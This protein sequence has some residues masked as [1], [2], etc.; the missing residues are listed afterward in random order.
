VT[1]STA[2][3]R[4]L[5]LA[6]AFALVAISALATAWTASALEVGDYQLEPCNP[7]QVTFR[8]Y[9]E[10]EPPAGLS[11]S[12]WKVVTRCP[13]DVE[14]QLES[15]AGLGT[16]WKGYGFP[17][18]NASGKIIK[19]AS[20]DLKGGDGSDGHL[21]Q[22]VLICNAG[23]QCSD[24]VQPLGSNDL[25]ARPYEFSGN[26]LPANPTKV[27]FLARCAAPPCS[28]ANPLR[29]QNLKIVYSD[30]V[31]PAVEFTDDPPDD[32]YL[33]LIPYVPGDPTS[34]NGVTTKLRQVHAIATDAGSGV[35]HIRFEFSHLDGAGERS[36]GGYWWNEDG[37]CGLMQQVIGYLCMP[38]RPDEFH[39]AGF[40]GGNNFGLVAGLNELSVQATDAAGN[41]SEPDTIAFRLDSTLPTMT[42][43]PESAG[44][45]PKW[46]AGTSFRVSWVNTGETVPTTTASGLKSARWTISNAY[47]GADVPAYKGEELGLRTSLDHITLPGDGLWTVYPKTVDYAN[48]VPIALHPVTVGVDSTVLEAPPVAPIAPVGGPGLKTGS[49]FSWQKPSNASSSP[50]GIC[51]YAM[52][53]DKNQSSDPGAGI[54]IGK[55][56]TTARLPDPLADGVNHLHFRAINCAG[57]LGKVSHVAFTVDASAPQIELTEPGPGGWYSDQYPLTASVVSPTEG[58]TMSLAYDEGSQNFETT[59]YINAP[60]K[61]GTHVLT[62]EAQDS[63]GNQSTLVTRVNIDGAAPVV[64]SSPGD[65]ANPT[66]IRG[67]ANDSGSGVAEAYLQYRAAGSADW[68]SF[69]ETVHPEGGTAKHLDLAGRL[70]DTALPDGAYEIQAVARDNAGHIGASPPSEVALPLRMAPQ[71]TASF[72]RAVTIEVCKKRAS[73]GKC[74]KKVK[75]RQKQT[76]EFADA[77][78]GAE[79]SMTGKLLDANGEPLTGAEISVYETSL[80]APRTFKQRVTT[81]ANGQYAYRVR[82]GTSRRITAHFEG[83]DLNAP[84]EAVGRFLVHPKIEFAVSQH[85]RGRHA[86][87]T[88]SGK[89]TATG[90]AIPATGLAFEIEYRVP[91]AKQFALSGRTDANGDFTLTRKFT[92]LK[93]PVRFTVRA[94]VPWF[95]GWPYEAGQSSSESFVI[96]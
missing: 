41:R 67:G 11:G 72:Q 80:V 59:S 48:N 70:P 73:S 71:I 28:V 52:L 22:M 42:L 39:F 66:L 87:V 90:A 49:Y 55:D 29:L 47:T 5:R 92:S 74:V 15:L 19:S 95:D 68:H 44:A 85:R 23:F 21:E 82:S 26:Q 30:T 3:S 43:A 1:R 91:G 63:F 54:E 79:R 9:G 46:Q 2:L 64:T 88:F 45:A 31:K 36:A 60:L 96:R 65:A 32:A 86:N 75:Q 25:T 69:G 4:A 93:R 89:V 84:A 8:G 34:W 35:Q 50:S 27:I 61:E 33:P 20:F 94:V 76:R 13:S 62:V 56:A 51:G 10:W 77:P 12:N 7:M 18:T 57:V 83:D 6:I 58:G 37:T 78:L 38:S 14:F 17:N 16:N 81:D 53:V 40:A 24:P